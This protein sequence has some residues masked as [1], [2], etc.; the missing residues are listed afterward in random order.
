MICDHALEMEISI[1]MYRKVRG[2][3]LGEMELLHLSIFPIATSHKVVGGFD[4][5]QEV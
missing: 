5:D 4:R 3:F 2:P 1:R